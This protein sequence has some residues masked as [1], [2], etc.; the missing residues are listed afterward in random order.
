MDELV[1]LER[2][3]WEALSSEGN[4]GRE[5]YASVLRE[6]AVMLFPGGVRLEG[7]EQ[8]LQSL[9]TQPWETFQLEQSRT[10]WL[11]RDAATLIYRVKAQRKGNKPYAALIS[12]TYVNE[13]GW[14][15]ALHQQTPI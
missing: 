10:M 3:G 13:G 1:D 12:S 2:Q 15:L 9:G 7:R 4:A 14:K 11:S 5:F 8:I 6:D